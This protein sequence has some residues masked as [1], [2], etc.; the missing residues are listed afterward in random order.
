MLHI[1]VKAS[2]YVARNG[3]KKMT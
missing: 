1:A 3:T 2:G